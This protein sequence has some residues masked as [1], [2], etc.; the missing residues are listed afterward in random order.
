MLRSRSSSGV[1]MR[2]CWEKLSF[3]KCDT[4]GV[5]VNDSTRC[6]CMPAKIRKNPVAIVAVRLIDISKDDRWARQIQ[7]CQILIQQLPQSISDGRSTNDCNELFE[8]NFV[9]AYI[10]RYR[11]IQLDT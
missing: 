3:K 6:S 5:I 9:V 2:F 8:K 11:S 10:A 4:R 7:C 1:A